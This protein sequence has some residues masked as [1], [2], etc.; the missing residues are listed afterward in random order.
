MVSSFASHSFFIPFLTSSFW[1]SSNFPLFF[2]FNFVVVDISALH[3]N[4]SCLHWVSSSNLLSS[5][6]IHMTSD[7]KILRHNL[8]LCNAKSGFVAHTIR[9]RKIENVHGC[10]HPNHFISSECSFIS[11]YYPFLLFDIHNFEI[12]C[13]SGEIL[14]SHMQHNEKP[15]TFLLSTPTPTHPKHVQLLILNGFPLSLIFTEEKMS[16]QSNPGSYK[17]SDKTGKLVASGNSFSTSFDRFDCYHYWCS[18]FWLHG[19]G[20]VC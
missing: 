19:R 5:E 15:W 17:L 1:L 7:K 11:I 9:L 16:I 4:V 8:C 18:F 2:N 6:N 12:I 13:F 10:F 14:F 20:R 3:A